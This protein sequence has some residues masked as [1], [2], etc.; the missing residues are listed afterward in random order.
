VRLSGGQAV[1]GVLAAVGCVVGGMA[2]DVV[3]A[4]TGIIL[5]PASN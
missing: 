5:D 1:V 3:V 2:M 4:D